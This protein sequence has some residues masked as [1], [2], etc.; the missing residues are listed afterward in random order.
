MS[1]PNADLEALYEAHASALYSFLL[2]LT[3]SESDT[4][5]CLQET[6][7]R[8]ISQPHLLQHLH[9]PHAFLFKIAYRVVIDQHR[10]QTTRDRYASES[11]PETIFEI[12]PHPDEAHFRQEVEKA[13]RALPPDQRA[14][15]HLKLWEHMTFEE[16]AQTLEL[17]P[18]TTASRYRYG[19]TKLRDTLRHLY[20]EIR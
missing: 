16:I 19:L 20:E 2:N 12:S 9:Q 6:F 1:H 7:C 17:S 5:D 14:V 13:M 3:R 11:A 18:N 10:R 4:K 8:L 15:V